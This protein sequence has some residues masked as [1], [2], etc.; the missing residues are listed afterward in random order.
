MQSAVQRFASASGTK[1]LLRVALRVTLNKNFSSVWRQK[2]GL[3]PGSKNQTADFL[4]ADVRRFL[5]WVLSR[6]D[7]ETHSQKMD[8]S[9]SSGGQAEAYSFYP[10][11]RFNPTPTYVNLESCILRHEP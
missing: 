11:F 10:K 1:F 9:L 4:E 8:V 5:P 3:K 7:N 2:R 6:H